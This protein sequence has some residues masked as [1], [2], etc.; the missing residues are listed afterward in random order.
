ML[1]QSI[2]KVKKRKEYKALPAVGKIICKRR[3]KASSRL[4]LKAGITVETACI[5][6]LFLWAVLGAFYLCELVSIQTR[7][8]GGIREAGRKMALLSYG[9][10]S[11]NSDEERG[12]G[13]GEVIG[14][15]LTAAYARSV[16]LSQASLEDTALKEA[17]ISLAASDFSD[18]NIVDLKVITSVRIPIPVY[19]IRKLR[20]MERG[21]VRAW[22]G[23]APD[24]GKEGMEG[25]E[26][27]EMVYVAVTGTVYHRSLT[28]THIKRSISTGSL[29]EMKNLR[30]AGGAKYYACGCCQAHPS[31]TVYY[32]KNGNRY[33]STLEC[34]QLKRTV[35]KVPLSSVESMKPCSKCG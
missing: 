18:K 20:F 17:G 29:S 2:K 26:E 1:F 31:E 23:R 11:G 6:P 35:K 8:V 19:H 10:Y 22:T 34:S 13:A 24:D 15:A 33:H 9:I 4:F 7:M 30:N 21:R 3:E 5:L 28:C 14:G 27:E 32:T 16:I 12:V 25:E